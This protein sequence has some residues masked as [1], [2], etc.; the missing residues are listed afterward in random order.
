MFKRKGSLFLVALLGRPADN[1]RMTEPAAHERTVRL[2]RPPSADGIGVFSV[3]DRRR[4]T[5]YAFREIACDIGG[6]GFAVHKLGL[7]T[8]YHV[9]VGKPEEYSCECMGF[10]RHGK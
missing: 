6:R 2:M 7:G 4:T 9:R 3:S 10:L 5:F 8:L 1:R